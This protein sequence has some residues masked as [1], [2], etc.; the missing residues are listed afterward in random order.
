MRIGN[1]RSGKV[2]E[3]IVVRVIV[4]TVVIGAMVG[5]GCQRV[6]FTE[7]LPRSQY[8]RYQELRGQERRTREIGLYGEEKPA[9]RE[10][11][12]PLGEP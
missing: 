10:R 3:A 1:G 4:W 12:R 2:L 8:Q 5:G 9:L 6:L 7:N 11:L